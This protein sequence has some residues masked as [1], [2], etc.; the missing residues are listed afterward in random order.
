MP[1]KPPKPALSRRA[2]AWLAAAF[3]ALAVLA[4]AVGYAAHRP[5]PAVA[6]SQAVRLADNPYTFVNP[7]L[8][9]VRPDTSVPSPE[10]KA[11]DDSVQSYI[12]AQ[13]ATGNVQ[14]ASVYFVNYGKGGSFGINQDDAYDPASLL[15]VVVM[16]AYL[17]EADTAPAILDASIVYP[18]AVA[19]SED[20][21]FATPSEL[22]VG[23]SYTVSDLID[24]M[25]DDSDN[26]AMDLLVDSID[27]KYL[28][29]VYSDLDIPNPGRDSS[30]YM[31]S[32]RDY[33][34]FFR[35]LYNATYVSWDN[36]E[37][38][39]SILSKATFKDGLVAGLPA[40]TVVAHK[41]GEHVTAADGQAQAV[42][43]HDCGI[44]YGAGGP[45]LLCV[46][47]RATSL[48][49]ASSLIAGISSMVHTALVA[50]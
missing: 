44:V 28:N 35:V 18:Q 4:F 9:V 34:L 48:S 20:V 22:V 3:I 25:I 42:E 26:G 1:A 19:A 46:M 17:K 8:A 47:T 23:Q 43:L 5:L 40:G 24:K 41:F 21:P 32:A 10:Y 11:L 39:L 49:A 15:K 6:G 30:N 7:L 13:I 2:K 31:I 29:G 50:H 14:T 12:Q 36:S 33:S 38:A 37:R 16:M 45:Y 27:Q